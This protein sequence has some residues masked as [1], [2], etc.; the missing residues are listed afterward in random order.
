MEVIELEE[1]DDEFDMQDN[2][3][4]E[5]ARLNSDLYDAFITN[6]WQPSNARRATSSPSLAIEE[7]PPFP[8]PD[9]TTSSTWPMPV[10]SSTLPTSSQQASLRRAA[11]SRMVDFNDFTHRRRSSNRDVIRELSRELSRES[12]GTHPNTAESVTEPRDG[13][14][15]WSRSHGRRF[16]PFSR[17]RQRETMWSQVSDSLSADASDESG[18]HT[19]EPVMPTL[20]DAPTTSDS[21]SRASP[22]AEDILIRAPRLRRR[23]MHAPEPQSVLSR[24]TSPVI[25]YVSNTGSPAATPPARQ[26]ENELLASSNEEPIAY[27]TPGSSEN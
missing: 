8:L 1:E 5:G 21:Y 6:P 15:T 2:A 22:D 25:V 10:G 12:P 26:H 23:N 19:I 27:P 3:G 4:V 14:V 9:S 24:H 11:R 17:T 16:F 7:W 18:H 13:T 20:F